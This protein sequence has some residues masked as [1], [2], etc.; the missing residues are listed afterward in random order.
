MKVRS[1]RIFIVIVVVSFLI[2]GAGEVAI[3]YIGQNNLREQFKKDTLISTPKGY[4]FNY[5]E[6]EEIGD[7]DEALKY[8][9]YYLKDRTWEYI[10]SYENKPEIEAIYEDEAIIIYRVEPEKD[11]LILIDKEDKT[12]IDLTSYITN[13]INNTN[14]HEVRQDIVLQTAKNFLLD[15]VCEDDKHEE[16]FNRLIEMMRA[17]G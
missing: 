17:D 7:N 16:D 14:D 15:Y 11:E 4:K 13:K 3:D 10:S 8:K 5:I 12:S 9:L 1:F 6:N 2:L